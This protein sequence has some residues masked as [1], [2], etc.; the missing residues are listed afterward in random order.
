VQALN[1]FFCSGGMIEQFSHAF[2]FPVRPQPGQKPASSTLRHGAFA[3]AQ[4]HFAGATTRLLLREWC[5]A[6]TIGRA[7]GG[8]GLK[9][10]CRSKH[11]AGLKRV[12]INTPV[13]PLGLKL[14]ASAPGI[15]CQHT[16]RRRSAAL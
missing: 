14:H 8:Y 12:F 1:T 5:Q 4:R 9:A 2:E 11:Q 16:N 6:G 3:M 15:A 10:Y 7:A 13:K